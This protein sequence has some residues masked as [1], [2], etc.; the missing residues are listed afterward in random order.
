MGNPTGNA[1]V[2]MFGMHLRPRGVA[3]FAIL[4]TTTHNASNMPAAAPPIPS[5]WI[6]TMGST[7]W[8]RISLAQD[9]FVPEIRWTSTHPQILHFPTF[10]NSSIG[11]LSNACYLGS[12]F[13]ESYR[14]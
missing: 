2:G 8:W 12:V 9:R 7:K 3:R 11:I 13:V 5:I 10:R 4:S 1:I 6:G 14:C